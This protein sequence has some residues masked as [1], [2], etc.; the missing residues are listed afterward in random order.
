VESIAI[1]KAMTES[2]TSKLQ[3]AFELALGKDAKYPL[4]LDRYFENNY[5]QLSQ[6]LPAL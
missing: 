5:Q 2:A 3:D 4:A 1:R 6:L